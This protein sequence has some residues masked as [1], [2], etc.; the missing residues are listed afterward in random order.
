MTTLNLRGIIPA[1]ILPMTEAYE[2][3]FA[4]LERYLNWV[5]AQGPVALAINADT[6]EGPHLSR[7]ERRQVLEAAVS[8]AAGRCGVIAGIGGP[9]TAAAVEN[10]RDAKAAGADA[11]LVFPI[12]AFQGQALDPEVPY[13][14][15]KAIAQ[16][17]DLPIILFQLQP[18]LGGVIYSQEALARL[19]EID[20]VVALKE[21]SF[22]ALQFAR[23]RSLIEQSGRSITLLSG[24]DNFILHSLILG[25][26]GALI[27]FGTLATALQVQMYQA[28]MERRYDEAFA[29]SSV[30]QPLADEIFAPPVSTYR[31]RTKEALRLLGVL[32]NAVVRPPLL[33]L[34]QAERE[35][36]RQ[37]LVRAGQ[38]E[39]FSA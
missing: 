39:A 29:L 5:I 14:Y 28:A 32:P 11:L 20:N 3:D 27:G 16:A 18:A 10:A 7:S 15:H 35:R 12:S 36:V 33:G 6:G 38:L 25:A 19:L 21:A 31:A 1:T 30:L 34:G 4:T 23:T 22:D 24:N 37:A 2:P 13:E 17:A 9:Y 26:E 8:A